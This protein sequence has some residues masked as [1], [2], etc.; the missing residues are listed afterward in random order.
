MKSSI[1]T[2]TRRREAQMAYN[3]MH[4]ITP[5]STVRK[6]DESLKTEDHSDLYNKNKKLD[7][8]PKSEREAMIKELTKKMHEAAKKLEFEEAAKYRNQ[9]TKLR[10]L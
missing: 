9:I 3:K 1:D 5:K 2:T 6:L 7:K 10:A 8:L 4:N